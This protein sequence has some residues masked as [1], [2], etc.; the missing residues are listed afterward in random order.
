MP[1]HYS[2]YHSTGKQLD[3]SNPNH[4]FYDSQDPF[5]SVLG[6]IRFK[7]QRLFPKSEFKIS[8]KSKALRVVVNQS[9]K[10]E[11]VIEVTKSLLDRENLI[12]EEIPEPGWRR[13]FFV[14]KP[15]IKL[16][17]SFVRV[18]V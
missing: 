3:P 14:I 16:T 1:K 5:L 6:P 13:C 11:K 15:Q 9:E 10:L 8:S 7:L 17:S 4:V 12:Y 18:K 2:P